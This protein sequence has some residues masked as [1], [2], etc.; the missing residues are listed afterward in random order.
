[1]ISRIDLGVRLC[2]LLFAQRITPQAM[3][4]I[5]GELI[6]GASALFDYLDR[7]GE[8]IDEIVKNLGIAANGKPT[9]PIP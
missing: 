7:E 4:N 1:M 3:I 8:N 5:K 9:R 2:Y 6:A